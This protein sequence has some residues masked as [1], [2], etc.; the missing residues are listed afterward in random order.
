MFGV[1]VGPKADKPEK[2]YLM[3]ESAVSVKIRRHV[4]VKADLNPFD[5]EWREYLK[6]RKTRKYATEDDDPHLFV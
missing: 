2:R 1:E 3:L 6:L 5:E 4:K